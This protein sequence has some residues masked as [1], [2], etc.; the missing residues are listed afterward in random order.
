MADTDL[1]TDTVADKLLA[2][3]RKIGTPADDG[4]DGDDSND[5]GTLK[6]RLRQVLAE[7]KALR[8][9]VSEL[10]TEVETYKASASKALVAVKE[11]S[12]KEVKTVREQFDAQISALRQEAETD[13]GLV[14]I[15]LTDPLGRKAA[16]DAYLAMPEKDRPPSVIDYLRGFDAQHKQR[17]E[18]LGQD[19]ADPTKAP[20]PPALPR[21]LVGY[22]GDRYKD[23]T[24][25]ASADPKRAD[26][27]SVDAG[28]TG[29][30]G[31]SSVAAVL[32]D[33]E[34]RK[35]PAK[36]AEALRR[37]ETV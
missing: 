17:V 29:R 26:P 24:P 23:P 35:D 9:T 13:I 10:A 19:K 15:G 12:A 4:D 33:P 27:A 37:L 28:A 18:F 34:L 22:L 30:A 3:L 8:D 20:P 7:K 25:A 1:D 11:Q 36:L 31:K 21:S 32:Q 14:E 5:R 2:R 6:A 16:R